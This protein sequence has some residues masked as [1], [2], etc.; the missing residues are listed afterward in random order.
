MFIKLIIFGALAYVFYTES[1]NLNVYEVRYDEKCA[2]LRGT[3][4]SCIVS[5][6]PDVD[7]TNPAV[8]YRLDNFY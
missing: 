3:G 5:F 8:F 1:E 7:L 2:S 4:T 6:T